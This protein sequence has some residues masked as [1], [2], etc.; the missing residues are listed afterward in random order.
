LRRL[1]VRATK[2]GRFFNQKKDDFRNI[3]S[4]SKD[5]DAAVTSRVVALSIYTK[6]YELMSLWANF[7][8]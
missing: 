8:D 1:D 3:A 4:F 6:V 7:R 2:T 5:V